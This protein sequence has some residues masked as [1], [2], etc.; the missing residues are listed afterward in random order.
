M[1][2]KKEFTAQV[3]TK[4]V[5]TPKCAKNVVFAPQMALDYFYKMLGMINGLSSKSCGCMRVHGKAIELTAVNSQRL[6][7][8]TINSKGMHP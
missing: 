3:Y 8:W 1:K 2:G 6:V 5:N 4:A 7:I